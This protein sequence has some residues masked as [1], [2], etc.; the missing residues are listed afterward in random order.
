MLDNVAVISNDT[1]DDL[2]METKLSDKEFKKLMKKHR[3]GEKSGKSKE[4][5]EPDYEELE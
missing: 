1:V 3:L 2:L 4:T 5:L